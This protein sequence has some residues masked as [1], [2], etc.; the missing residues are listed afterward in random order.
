MRLYAFI[1]TTP[2]NGQEYFMMMQAT[3]QHEI[4]ESVKMKVSTISNSFPSPSVDDIPSLVPCHP[5]QTVL[6]TAKMLNKLKH[7]FKHKLLLKKTISLKVYR[8]RQISVVTGSRHIS[9]FD[10]FFFK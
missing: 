2:S 6:R 10:F 7:K 3:G 1:A 5:H 9:F 8:Q 4:G